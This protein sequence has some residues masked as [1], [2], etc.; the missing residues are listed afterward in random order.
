VVGF[1]AI[2]HPPRCSGDLAAVPAMLPTLSPTGLPPQPPPRR[3]HTT[4][5]RGRA[6]R[7]LSQQ[8]KSLLPPPE[9]KNM[10]RSPG[11]SSAGN[12]KM[13]RVS[14]P[15]TCETVGRHGAG[16][17]AQF[18]QPLQATKV[19]ASLVAPLPCQPPRVICLVRPRL[20]L[21]EEAVSEQVA[22]LHPQFTE[23]DHQIFKTV[24][25]VSCASRS[26]YRI[27][28][29]PGSQ[30]AYRSL[31]HKPSNDDRHAAAFHL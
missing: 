15:F 19:N 8:L 7:L 10:Q 18:F 22:T 26:C 9:D 12:L 27:P 5:H 30:L 1:S 13:V 11:L 6:S 23:K 4:W 28:K 24:N 3:F 20:Q 16:A 29:Q 21:V 25:R 31:V 14:R 2:G 17:S